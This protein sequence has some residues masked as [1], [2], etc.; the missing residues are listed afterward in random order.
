MDAFEGI[1]LAPDLDSFRKST[2][3]S[4]QRVKEDNLTPYNVTSRRMGNGIATKTA[5]DTGVKGTITEYRDNVVDVLDGVIGAISGGLLNTKDI[6]K[7][8]KVGR[9]GVT[10]STDQ[11]LAAASKQL[12]YPVSSESGA[13]RKIAGDINKEFT[14]LTGLNL[15]GLVQTDGST[16]KAN[17]NWRGIFGTETA[18]AVV[19]ITG[20]D[21]FLDRSVTG[22]LYNSIYKS[23]MEMGMKDSYRSLWN[24]YPNGF[25]SIRRDG[26]I[27]AMQVMVTNGDIESINE[28]L[29][30]LDEDDE[31][32]GTNRAMIRSKYPNFVENLFS[33][34]RF[35]DSVYPEDYEALRTL[36]LEVLERI[37]GQNW[38][39]TYTEFGEVLN[40]AIMTRC[41]KDMIT[42]LSGYP[43]IV[44]LLTTAG[45]FSEVSC[46][47]E[48]KNQFR[49]APQFAR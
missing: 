23:A 6:T 3:S 17:K 18:R 8:I 4:M 28:V 27:E 10:F 29:K 34:F 25:G 21:Q 11:I 38:W 46:L 15:G 43:P 24:S 39:M 31:G 12:G 1:N 41:S 32:L 13:M 26:T 45:K 19:R 44:P 48:L 20:M 36:L 35:D 40:L 42:L 9:D 47:V 37:Q 30:L 5:R 2:N 16:F 49:G 22:S 7:A 33:N 14:R